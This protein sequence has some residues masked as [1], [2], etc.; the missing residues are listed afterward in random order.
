MHNFLFFLSS[1]DKRDILFQ[2][3]EK[4]SKKNSTFIEFKEKDW[5]KFLNE[6]S[7]AESDYLN[8]D[9]FKYTC[10]NEKG[11]LFENEFIQIGSITNKIQDTIL[12]NNFYFGNKTKS[13]IVIEKI[14][15]SNYTFKKSKCLFL[16]NK[17]TF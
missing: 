13:D 15:V 14:E 5:Q 8:L 7:L 6:T 4:K 10:V 3:P 12:R 2:S 16:I 11:V 17:K 1:K 9:N